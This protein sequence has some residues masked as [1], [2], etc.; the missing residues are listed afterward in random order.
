MPPRLR[1]EPA[2]NLQELAFAEAA[3]YQVPE[4][5]LTAIGGQLMGVPAFNPDPAV[6]ERYFAEA[7]EPAARRAFSETTVPQIASFFAARNANRG[8]AFQRQLATAAENLETNLAGIRAGLL[9]EDEGRRFASLENAAQRIPGGIQQAIGAG[10]LPIQLRASLGAEQR[11]IQQ[12]F[13]TARFL[14][15]FVDEQFDTAARLEGA[16]HDLARVP[17]F[18]IGPSQGGGGFDWAGFV[19]GLIN[20]VGNLVGGFL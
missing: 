8:G 16:I 19:S 1:V 14:N 5:V 11:G 6:R 12:Q 18:E 9:S 17:P 4:S 2:N 15:Q 7:V 13:N 3:D 20:P 10:I